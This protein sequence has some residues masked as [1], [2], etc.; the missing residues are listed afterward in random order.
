MQ[1]ITLIALRFLLA[2]IAGC[3]PAPSAPLPGDPPQ[4]APAKQPDDAPAP[5]AIDPAIDDLLT[6]LETSDRDLRDFKAGITYDKWDSVLGRDEKRSGT[7]IYQVRPDGNKRFA[8]LFDKLVVTNG[9]P[10]D[11]ATPPGRLENKQHHY[12][13]DAGWLA[14]IDLEK[15]QFIKQQIVAPGEKFDPLKLGEGPFPLPVGQAKKDVLARFEVARAE[16]P[17][18]G[19]LSK[20]KPENVEGLTLIPRPG[21]EEAKDFSRVEIFYD[22][23]TLLPVGVSTFGAEEVVAGERDRKTVLLFDAKRNEGVDESKLSIETPDAATGWRI[24]VRP[25]K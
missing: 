11:P 24:D 14:E 18:E 2:L 6:R 19:L 17:K 7:L 22:K 16:L 20:L 5:G 9:D 21:T 23:A 25:W 13:F 15:K 10:A 1:S 12:V 3:S 8:I 4:T